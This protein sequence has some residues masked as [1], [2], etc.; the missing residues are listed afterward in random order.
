MLAKS[1]RSSIVSPVNTWNHITLTHDNVSNN[2]YFNGV[3]VASESAYKLA[4]NQSDLLIGYNGSNKNVKATVD[5]IRVY[6]R[7]ITETEVQTIY[8][9]EAVENC[10]GIRLNI[11]AK[12][13]ANTLTFTVSNGS[14]NNK[15]RLRKKNDSGIFTSVYTPTYL[16]LNNQIGE[17]KSLTITGLQDGIYD[18]YAYCGSDGTKYQGYQ[19]V[20]SNGSAL[21]QTVTTPEGTI[22]YK[23]DNSANDESAGLPMNELSSDSKFTIYPNPTDNFVYISTDENEII[24]FVKVYNSNGQQVFEGLRAEDNLEKSINVSSWSSGSYILEIFLENKPSVKKNFI[25]K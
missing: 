8:H 20:I 13:Q 19:F 3:L 1:T 21:I 15:Y 2:F 4:S 7:A 23:Y 6:K 10:S 9:N 24:K 25:L 22:N 5:E 16:S 17:T 18:I 14:K 12:S 11:D